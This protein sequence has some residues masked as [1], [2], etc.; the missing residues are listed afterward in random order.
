MKIETK[1]KF[2]DEVFFMKNNRVSS[3]TIFE[4]NVRTWISPMDNYQSRVIQNVEYQDYG[5]HNKIREEDCFPSKE[6]LLKS[7]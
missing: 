7:L 1:Y 4:I 3:M 6:E 2:G 5:S